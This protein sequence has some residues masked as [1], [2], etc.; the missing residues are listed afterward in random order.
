MEW[1]ECPIVL[2]LLTSYTCGCNASDNF[3]LGCVRYFNLTLPKYPLV[4]KNHVNPAIETAVVEMEIE[5]PSAWVAPRSE[6]VKKAG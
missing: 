4:M 6:R 3:M 5:Q 1:V 2:L